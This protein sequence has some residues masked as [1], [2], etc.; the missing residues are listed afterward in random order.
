MVFK[1]GDGLN[2]GFGERYFG[3]SV[4]KR[5]RQSFK[6]GCLFFIVENSVNVVRM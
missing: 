1:K 6:E 4:L 3:K 5:V 2:K